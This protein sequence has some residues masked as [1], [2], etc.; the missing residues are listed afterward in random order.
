M[1]SRS[2]RSQAGRCRRRPTPGLADIAGSGTISGI[3]DRDGRS[4]SVSIMELL[5]VLFP[6]LPGLRITNVLAKRPTVHVRGES[7]GIAARC[8]A[9]STVSRR[10]RTR[11]ER[12]LLDAPVGGRETVL[13]LRVRRFI[14]TLADC[15]RQ[16]VAE[17]IDGV[18]VRHGRFSALAR[19]GVE[20]VAL[21]LAGRAGARPADRLGSYVGRMT[22]LRLVRALPEPPVPALTV[23]GVDEF[24]WRR[25]HSYGTVLVNIVSRRV[26]D[27]LD[28]RSADGLAAWLGE[29]PGAEV[30]CR[31]R[32][33]CYA[34]GA[35][36]GSPAAVQVADR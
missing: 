18:T 24:A 36:R 15:V 27:V 13:H 10:V 5:A 23:L 26:I 22:L 8:P 1:L 9:Y 28:D 20:A 17:Q 7:G 19:Q 25:G 3:V 32:A 29:H 11:Y 21:A 12:R 16:N 6:H 30:I 4:C 33:G 14:C 34:E 31:D 2:A 35:T